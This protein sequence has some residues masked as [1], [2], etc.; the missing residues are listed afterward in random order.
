MPMKRILIIE[1]E[2]DVVDLVAMNLRGLS[3]PCAA[4]AIDF[5]INLSERRATQRQFRASQSP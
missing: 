3:R 2:A 4:T 1:D 5:A